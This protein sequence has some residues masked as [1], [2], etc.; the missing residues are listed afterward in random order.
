MFWDLGTTKQLGGQ[1]IDKIHK[2]PG[3][4]ISS[5]EPTRRAR[6][7]NTLLK[8]RTENGDLPRNKEKNKE[9][10]NRKCIQM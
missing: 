5:G 4:E 10:K 6:R 9:A 8:Q 7:F 1:W 3:S 2:Q